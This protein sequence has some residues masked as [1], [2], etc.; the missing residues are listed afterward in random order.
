MPR[1][2]LHQIA[3]IVNGS[4]I[5]NTNWQVTKIMFDSRK[6]FLPA[7]TLFLAI[8]GVNRDGHQ[9]IEPLYRKGVRIFMV[10][11]PAIDFKIHCPE[12]GFI[13]VENS[14]RALQF[15]ATHHRNQL[16]FPLIGITGSNGKTIVKEWIV[17]LIEGDKKT[18]RSP[19]SFNSQLGV[20]LSLWMMDEASELGIVEAGISLPGE[21]KR[22]EQCLLPEIGIMT[23][24]GQAHQ[25][26]FE[27]LEQ[28]LDEKLS[29]FEHSEIILY[30][31]DHQRVKA[32]IENRY[33][34]K[35]ILTCGG[36]LECDLQLIQCQEENDSTRMV[37]RWKTQKIEVL[38]P[39][40]GSVAVENMLLSALAVLHV[41][42]RLVDLPERITQLQP[43][44]M[45]L[46]QKEGIN[47]C[48]LIDDAYNSDITSL[49][50]ALDFLNQM[51]AK[52]GLSKTLIL[53]DIFQSGLSEVELYH[54]VNQLVQEKGVDRF[55]G[56]GPSIYKALKGINA[57]RTPEDFMHHFSLNSFKNEAILLKGSRSFS[58]ERI[59]A[60]LEQK[61]HK[62]TLEINLNALADNV[63]FFRGLLQPQTKL[64][65]MVKAF[66]Y[67][68]GSFEIAN[69]LQHQ[70][71][72]YL[73]VAFADEG[74]E[75]RQAGITLPIIVMNPEISSFPMML[76]YYLEPEIYSFQILES[77]AQATDRQGLSEI[78]IHIK[79]DTGMNR[80]GFLKDDIDALIIKLKRYPSL[81]VKSVFS[82]LA[83]SDEAVHDDFTRQQIVDF[84]LACQK[85][86]EGLGYSFIRHTLNSAGIE[87]FPEAQFE[88]VRLG[89]GMYG[90][91]AKYSDHLEQ[92]TALK[93]YVSQLKKVP[94]GATIG[95]GRQGLASKDLTIAI[96]PVGYADGLD[97][98]LSQGVGHV[99]INGQK[100]PI[101][102]NIC[103]DMCMADVTGLDV[104]EGAGVELFGDSYTIS[105]MAA[106]I[107]TIPY[108]ILTGISRR[109]KRIY[110]W[111]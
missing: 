26:N 90:I 83:G 52:K 6:V 103:M 56:I 82:H 63:N 3:E 54:K 53:S 88:M 93:S 107:H 39:F 15:L 16:P 111:E 55:I 85:L 57:Y 20:P 33:P 72:D 99:L 35:K 61:R 79:V 27:S 13:Q 68:S 25:E 94:A 98:R 18:V 50:L 44:A 106:D 14:L 10:E 89:I 105:D 67:G 78:G 40:T 46:E 110:Y 86:R 73:G 11:K 80:L 77:F 9:Y 32:A 12:A 47:N 42:T 66:S 109:V 30:N 21:M 108:E 97:R 19:R 76:Q 60:L 22:I 34:N 36:S 91:G 104:A 87:R 28:K 65:A 102:G 38:L 49:E 24:I 2:S 71:V 1:Y 59:S 17:K 75:L 64:L 74:I 84:E 95:Y 58:F 101:I 41:G 96:V 29:L 8:D 48:L 69:L 4:L 5:G 23:N 62:T 37:M 92:V 81:Y 7:D 100:A 31:G 51:G 70:N 45:R 43:V